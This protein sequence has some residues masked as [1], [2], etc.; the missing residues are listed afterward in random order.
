MGVQH[1]PRESNFSQGGGSNCLFPTETH[2]ICHFPVGGRGVQT[3][4]PPWSSF[5]NIKN[6]SG[7]VSKLFI[8][9]SITNI[10]NP[11]YSG[12]PLNRYY[13]CTVSLNTK[14]KE[15]SGT[16]TKSQGLDVMLHNAAINQTQEE[17]QANMEE[18]D[19]ERL[20]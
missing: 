9:S 14:D 3:P 11:L 1:L 18:T 6:S 15:C 7:S 16:F 2:I 12:K 4:C 13:G 19:G 10:P 17:A 20:R 5:K 8:L